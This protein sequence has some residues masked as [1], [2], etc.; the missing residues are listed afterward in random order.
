M[1]VNPAKRFTHLKGVAGLSVCRDTGRLDCMERVGSHSITFGP[2][3]IL[4]GKGNRRVVPVVTDPEVQ[5][6]P[7]PPPRKR[8]LQAT[9]PHFATNVVDPGGA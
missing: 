4:Q 2:R 1:Q 8:S 5:K 3:W 9:E 6:H 7:L